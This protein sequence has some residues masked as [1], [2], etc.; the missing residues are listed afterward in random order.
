MSLRERPFEVVKK[1]GAKPSA[2]ELRRM[3]D[4]IERVSTLSGPNM[5]GD[6]SGYHFRE[7]P[8]PFLFAKLTAHSGSPPAYTWTQAIPDGIGGWVLPTDG[9][10]GTPA[11]LPCYEFNGQTV[12]VP[13]YVQLFKGSGS[14]VYF[15]APSGTSSR[16]TNNITYFSN[17]ITNEFVTETFVSSHVTYDIDTTVNL[18]GTTRLGLHHVVWGDPDTSLTTVDDYDLP[19]GTA[20]L[21]VELLGNV[22]LTS[23]ANGIRGRPL[24]IN[25]NSEDFT[26]LLAQD[27][28]V[29]GTA[30]NRFLLPGAVDNTI[31]S[32]VGFG[33]VYDGPQE[34]DDEDGPDAV[35]PSDRWLSLDDTSPSPESPT[36][37]DRTTTS[38][39]TICESGV[40]KLYSQA[41]TFSFRDGC[42]QID[43]GAWVF[44]SNQGQCGTGGGLPDAGGG[45]TTVN[46]CSNSLPTTLTCNVSAKTGTCTCLPDS[47]T[48]TWDSALSRWKSA[49]TLCGAHYFDLGCPSGSDVSHFNATFDQDS[50]GELYIPTASCSPVFSLMF[51]FSVGVIPCNGSFTVE[52]ME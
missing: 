23:I 50:F 42:L 43:T 12:T 24:W 10:S 15:F 3:A 13:S 6:G 31:L 51:T 39:R 32:Q 34:E 33:L 7:A 49:L 8:E 48:I 19:D 44:V 37:P 38:W 46:C 1:V 9:S 27:N 26:L 14:W 41:T 11:S 16:I 22:V 18:F 5:V 17:T 28:G 47:F 4:A 35:S 30:A 2:G 20:F 29:D 21:V 36:C 25:N 52:I 40:A 45:T